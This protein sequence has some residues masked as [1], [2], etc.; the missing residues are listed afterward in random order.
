MPWL[1]DP[2]AAVAALP[3]FALPLFIRVSAALEYII[4][5]YWGD[6]FVLLGFFVAG[7]GLAPPW[8]IFAAAFVGS[9]AGAM[10]AYALGKRFGLRLAQKLTFRRRP[11]SRDRLKRLLERFGEKLLLVN[12]FVPIIRG[13]LL[14]GAGALELR[15]GRTLIY[16]SV[17]NAGWLGILM[18]LGLYTAGTWEEIVA[19]FTRYNRIFG[20][21]AIV[22]VTFWAAVW[23]HRWRSQEKRLR[24]E[25]VREPSDVAELA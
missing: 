24:E 10:V 21:V 13:M 15:P 9:A 5:P 2:L 17:S 3:A 1:D 7:Q 16:S 8:L 19:T 4:P 23:W 14:Y 22:L 25:R 20:S 18:A 12:R 11:R 6:M